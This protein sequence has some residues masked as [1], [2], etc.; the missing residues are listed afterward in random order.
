VN[1]TL[2]SVIH[3]DNPFVDD[4]DSR[5][6]VRRFRGRL[7]APVTI[8]TAG[9]EADRTGL[10]VSSLV[11]VEGEPGRVEVVVGPTTDL[12][13]AAAGTG[14]FVIH[15]CTDEDRALTE[16]FA[17]LRPSPGGI[18]A[19]LEVNQSDW[20]PVIDRLTNR[21]YCTFEDRREVGYSGLI[22]G[23][24]DRV[25]VADLNRPLTYFRGRFHTLQ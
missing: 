1:L 4:P 14:R 20:G 21:A 9:G 6:P 24:I 3:S 17:G 5:D 23:T 12:W 15:V 8:V 10:T 2:A 18:F 16:V 7:S 25:E 19:G 13:D 11:I 22:S